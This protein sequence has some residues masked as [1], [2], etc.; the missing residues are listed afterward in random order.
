MPAI[1]RQISQARHR[2]R[3]ALTFPCSN[4]VLRAGFRG[5]GPLLRKPDTPFA[6]ASALDDFQKNLRAL[7]A[8]LQEAEWNRSFRG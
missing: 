8:P 6:L 5:Q 2:R 1:H 4:G 3:K 7:R